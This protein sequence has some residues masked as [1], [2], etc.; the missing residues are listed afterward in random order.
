MKGRARIA[1]P[2]ASGRSCASTS[3]FM[4]FVRRRQPCRCSASEE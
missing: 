4:P 1:C 2:E 3:A